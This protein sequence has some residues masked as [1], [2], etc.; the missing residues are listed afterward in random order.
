MSHLVRGRLPCR[1]SCQA[2][3]SGTSAPV[4]QTLSPPCSP[5]APA[6]AAA[7]APSFPR[8]SRPPSPPRLWPR[9]AV[10]AAPSAA[11][12]TV[13]TILPSLSTFTKCELGFSQG[14]GGDDDVEAL[15]CSPTAP[16]SSPVAGRGRHGE[17]SW[18]GWAVGGWRRLGCSTQVCRAPKQPGAVL[19]SHGRACSGGWAQGSSA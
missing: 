17:V 16:S 2:S 15:P 8:C 14:G 9:R 3:S 4:T 5:P 10:A 1:R 7:A 12:A 6:P 19:V 18:G 11:L 13:E